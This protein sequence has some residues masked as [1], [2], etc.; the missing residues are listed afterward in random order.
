MQQGKSSATGVNADALA[1]VARL[2]T[3]LDGARRCL[4]LTGAGMSAESGI[5]P[6]RGGDQ[7]LWTRFDPA[8]L[9][10]PEA[11][12]ADPDLVWA[13]YLWRMAGVRAATPHAGHRALADLA[14]RQPGLAL[15]TQNVDD[16]HE[17]AGSTGVVH[18]HGELF[19]LRCAACAA[20]APPPTLPATGVAP[21]LRQPPPR[22]HRCGGAVRPGVVWFGE[23]LPEAAWQAAESAARACDLALVVGTSGL[24]HPAAALP[25]IARRHGARVVEINPAPTALSAQADLCW[26][27]TAAQA[28]PLLTGASAELGG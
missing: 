21:A 18:L 3:W 8:R 23:A 13:W 6:F 9:A 15:V 17:R 4:V 11:F 25:A 28:L 26:R 27:A 12:A 19:A 2:R 1:A 5:A 10:T 20:P 24:V 14:A 7:A 22:C 16:L